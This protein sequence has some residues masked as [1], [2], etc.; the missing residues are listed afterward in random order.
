MLRLPGPDISGFGHS[1][2]VTNGTGRLLPTFGGMSETYDVT[3]RP[4]VTDEH[5]APRA[6]PVPRRTTWPNAARVTARALLIAGFVLA[7]LPPLHWGLG[8]AAGA[9]AYLV[10]TA[11]VITAGVLAVAATDRQLPRS[12]QRHNRTDLGGG[13]Q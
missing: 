7:L 8:T 10:G 3:E 9:V 2:F 13:P 4:S 6:A 11:V 5:I 12:T 1:E